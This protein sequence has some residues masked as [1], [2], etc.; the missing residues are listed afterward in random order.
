MVAVTTDGNRILIT[1]S[2]LALI[3]NSRGIRKFKFNLIRSYIERFEEFEG[4]MRLLDIPALRPS[5]GWFWYIPEQY[6]KH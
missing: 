2:D 6:T 5:L 4:S 1:T 3:C